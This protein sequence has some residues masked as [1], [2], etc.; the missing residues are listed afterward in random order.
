M[1]RATKNE[2]AL[3]AA[4][5]QTREDKWTAEANGDGWEYHACEAEKA[6]AELLEI[7]EDQKRY[8]AVR[9]VLGLKAHHAHV[10]AC[11]LGS[12]ESVLHYIGENP[13]RRAR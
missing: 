10:R 12:C 1:R 3:I 6:N 8:D 11:R 5:A 7:I 2:R 9:K 13:P 4:L